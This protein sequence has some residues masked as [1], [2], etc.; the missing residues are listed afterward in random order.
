VASY[1][2]IAIQVSEFSLHDMAIARCTRNKIAP[3]AWTAL[4]SVAAKSPA[5]AK[6]Q[7]AKAPCRRT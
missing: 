1:A 7:E 2:T 4:Q 3:M 5:P 6:F